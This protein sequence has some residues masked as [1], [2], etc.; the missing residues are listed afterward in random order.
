MNSRCL[1]PWFVALALVGSAAALGCAHLPSYAVSPTP[2]PGGTATPTPGPS[3]TPSNCATQAP[4]TT[5]VVVISSSITAASV[6]PYG[7]ING[8]IRLNP[9]GSF[10]NVAA[11]ISTHTTDIIQF[12]NG[13]NTGPATIV[14]SAAGFS[15]ASFPAIPFTFPAIL[16]AQVGN[17]ITNSGSWSSGRLNPICFSQPLTASPGT[18]YFGDLDYYNLSN[19]R[20]VIV[21]S[22]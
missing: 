2:T 19:M 10:G 16:Q 7:A 17:A 3:S 8:Y 9:D 12:V 4:T 6:A 22:P 18:Y 20:D 15:T 11:V 1:T 13:E 14:H 21:V 5:V